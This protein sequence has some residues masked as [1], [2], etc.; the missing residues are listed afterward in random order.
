MA[1][2]PSKVFAVLVGINDYLG[3]SLNLSGCLNDVRTVKKFLVEANGVPPGNIKTL[4]SPP[5]ES[6]PSDLP[7]K[8]NFLDLVHSVAKQ[9]AEA[10]PDTLLFIH[11]SGHG[12]RV[13]TRYPDKKT[14]NYDEVLCT[15]D[16]PLTDVEVDGLLDGLAKQKLAVL[17]VLDCC[18]SG[19]AD[20]DDGQ[21]AIRCPSQPAQHAWVKSSDRGD[22]NAVVSESWF[23][24]GRSHNLL[25]ACQPHEFAR[26]RQD[27]NGSVV[28]VMSYFLYKALRNLQ[29]SSQ[30]VTYG[31]LMEHLESLCGGIGSLSR[32]QPM[33]LGDRTRLLFGKDTDQASIEG[34]HAGIIRVREQSIILDKGSV[35][36]IGLGDRFRLYASDQSRFGLLAAGARHA[37]EAQV[38]CVKSLAARATILNNPD[39][40]PER[41]WFARLAKRANPPIVYFSANDHQNNAISRLRETWERLTSIPAGP[42]ADLRFLLGSGAPAQE[43][44]ALRIELREDGTILRFLDGSST[45]MEHVPELRLDDEDIAKKLVYLLPHLCSYLRLANLGSVT[46]HRPAYTFTVRSKDMVDPEELEPAKEST[47]APLAYYDVDFQNDSGFPLYLTIFNLGPAYGVEQIFPSQGASSFAISPGDRIQTITL[48]IQAPELLKDAS[49]QPGFRMRD[50]FKAFIT[51]VEAHFGQYVQPD[52]ESWSEWRAQMSDPKPG[53]EPA[54]NAVRVGQSTPD[55]FWVDS[56]EIDT[57]TRYPSGV[58]GNASGGTHNN[59]VDVNGT[60]CG[61]LDGGNCHGSAVAPEPLVPS[62]LTF[63]KRPAGWN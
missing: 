41:G 25:A 62:T 11:Y 39:R 30:P 55:E 20:R 63:S 45:A 10:G 47:G 15:L 48:G 23:Y 7:T 56:R 49:K 59:D 54:R 9:A 16:E 44:P 50:T 1:I 35:H 8:R 6:G 51:T 52:L 18:H 32:Q 28:G 24:R 12:D 46:G 61:G 26:E 27:D 57:H 4:T 17:V 19:G 40:T 3:Q 29:A 14:G 2:A 43:P 34:L 38:D 58:D 22:R 31:K 60:G 53:E 5:L 21:G 42:P 33:H 13:D 37:A 36:G